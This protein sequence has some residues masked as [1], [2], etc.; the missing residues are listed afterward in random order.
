MF[1]TLIVSS[2]EYFKGFFPIVAKAWRKFFPEVELCAAFV[3]TKEENDDEVFKLR[4]IYDKVS[5]YRPVKGV[6]DKNVAKMSRFLLASSMGE[7][8]CSIEDVDTI[9]L[10]KKYFADRTSLREPD[11]ILAVGKEVYEG[12]AHNL[13]F[14][15]STATAEGDTFKKIFNPNDLE[16]FELYEFWKSFTCNEGRKI[17]DQNFS[18]EGLIVKLIEHFSFE[19]IQHVERGVDIR[20]DWVD[21]SWWGINEQKLKKGDYITCNF[22]RPFEENRAKFKQIID[23]INE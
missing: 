18:D 11:K 4:D 9:P 12:T 15:V 3:T 1:D 21:R 17:T 23:Y 16:Y 8:V 20:S 13:S 14:P 2:D 10:Q 7:K 5:L 19:N 22:L 6:P